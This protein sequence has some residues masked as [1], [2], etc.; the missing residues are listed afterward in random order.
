MSLEY[1]SFFDEIYEALLAA[2][3]ENENA[4]VWEAVLQYVRG[5]NICVVMGHFPAFVLLDNIKP[6]FAKAGLPWESGPYHRM[7]LVL[8]AEATDQDLATRLPSQHSQK[9]LFVK[10]V[11][12]A[13]S[14]YVTNA[15]SL[16]ESRVI[17]P[18][19]ADTP[20][21]TAVAF[22]RVGDGKLGYVGDV[23]A[24]KGSDAAILA[25]CGLL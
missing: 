2:L 9:P 13:D 14:S 4:H 7:T 5:G 23:N 25:M 10:N 19:N 21:K 8:N 1:K 12:P 22:A 20:G 18:E 11:A 17:P 15:G 6:F 3:T 24:E 16:T